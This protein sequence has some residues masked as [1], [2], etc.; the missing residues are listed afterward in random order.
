MQI[1][2][3]AAQLGAK[4]AQINDL[5]HAGA[6]TGV[7]QVGRAADVYPLETLSMALAQDAD[8]MNHR[9]DSGQLALEVVGAYQIDLGDDNAARVARPPDATAEA[10]HPMAGVGGLAYDMGSDEPGT[11]GYEYSHSASL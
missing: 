5:A 4:A 10:D 2:I 1:G 7:D 6:S 3:R 9:V 8:R 11:P